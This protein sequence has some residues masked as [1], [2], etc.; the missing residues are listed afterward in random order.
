MSLRDDLIPCV[1]DARGMADELGLRVRPVDLVV[2]TWDGASMGLGT[3]T[4][5]AT[6]I[7]PT[8]KV[9]AMDLREEGPGGHVQAGDLMISRISA[10]L[11]E[12]TLRGEPLAPKSEFIWRVDG[13][14]YQLIGLERRPFEWR[15][16]V[17][18]Q[19]R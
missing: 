10:A 5:T 18:R 9:R 16:Q 14:A 4:E 12:A 15:A 7:S 19:R 17:R 6:I 11:S 3:K 2:R 1:D 8:P 13:E